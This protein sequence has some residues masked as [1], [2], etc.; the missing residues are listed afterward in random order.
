MKTRRMMGA[1]TVLPMA[2]AHSHAATFPE[3]VTDPDAN[4]DVNAGTWTFH[5]ENVLGTSLQVTVRG[6]DRGQANN[7][8]AAALAVFDR[9]AAI[10]SAWQPESEFSRWSRTCFE[11]V[12]V[13]AEL[14]STLA[15]F[16]AWRER[17][18]GALDPSVEAAT[19]LWNRATAEGRV[20]TGA[21]I[22]QTV[23]A[24]AQPHWALNA[25]NR[26]ATRLSDVPLALASFVKSRITSEA[27]D[28]ALAAGAGGVVLNVG[29]DVVV[30]GAVTQM[31]AVSNP[32]HSADNDSPL[33]YVVVRNASVAT[34]GGYLRGFTKA[35]A[36]ADDTPHYSHL[37]D[38]RTAQ[39]VGHILS[40][41]VIARDSETAGALATAFSV[42]PVEESRRLAADTSGVDYLIVAADGQTIRSEGWAKHQAFARPS[43]HLQPAGWST[44]PKPAAGQ[45]NPAF[46]LAV[47]L[48]L[49]RIDDA[50]Y[51]RPYVAVWIEDADH[52]PVRTLSLWTQNPRWLP[53]LKQW[54]RDD[55][56]RNLSEGTDISRT[57]SSAT[58]PAGKYS[59][60]WD[61]K[62]N[63]G[64]LV[65]AGEYTVVVEA[66]REHGTYQV[67]RRSLSFT[68]KPDQVT[69]PAGQELG[70]VV[71]DYRK[72]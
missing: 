36:A 2:A 23:E 39:P 50:R 22:A 66:S 18:G 57:V 29:G 14:F 47:D 33:D 44:P 7:A 60:K 17:T 64:R 67:E 8:E 24:I 19:R 37:I 40:S 28:A 58:R 70:T 12:P 27:A 26:T 10:L 71:F 65:K 49:P 11:D 34:S 55:Q 63:E 1:L 43:A 35:G 46:E 20:P 42:L 16:D 31:V 32:R 61:G 72:R 38:P 9:E 56:I 21:E 3:A 5:H 13:S 51:R 4:Q 68:G 30:R 41:T 53:E 54:Y 69:L 25:E 52:F 59:L 45:W 15:A 62:D 6:A 48:T